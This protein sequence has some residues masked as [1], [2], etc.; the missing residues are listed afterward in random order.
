MDVLMMTNSVVQ[1]IVDCNIKE[2]KKNIIRF[3]WLNY[4]FDISCF[5]SVRKLH[6]NLN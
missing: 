1:I 4:H 6:V 5:H 2:T 3:P